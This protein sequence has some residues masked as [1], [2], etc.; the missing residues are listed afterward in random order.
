MGLGN[1]Y[2]GFYVCFFSLVNGI[3]I[4]SYGSFYFLYIF[5]NIKGEVSIFCLNIVY[6]GN[7]IGFNYGISSGKNIG[8]INGFNGIDGGL[9]GYIVFFDSGGKN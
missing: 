9:G 1:N 6:N 5:M 2:L 7:F 3:N 8:K 4:S